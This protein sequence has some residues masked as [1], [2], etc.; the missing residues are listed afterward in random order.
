MARI[1]NY[2]L[3]SRQKAFADPCTGQN[4]EKSWELIVNPDVDVYC[5]L[6]PENT[7]KN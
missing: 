1:L 6:K 5:Y 3:G 7:P 2:V 4:S